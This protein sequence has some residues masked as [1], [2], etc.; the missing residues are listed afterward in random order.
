MRSILLAFAMF[1]RLPV[2]RPEWTGKNMRFIMAAFPAVGVVVGAA[3][4]LWLELAEALGFGPF[5]T[6]VGFAL[7]PLLLTGGIHMDGF[8]DTTDAL[9]SHGDREKK[10]RILKDPH[11][12]SFASFLAA[13]YLMAFA[14]LASEID[15]DS[16]ALWCFPLLFVLSRTAVGMAIV[17]CPPAKGSGL[18]KTFHDAAATR[19]SLAILGAVLFIVVF[20]FAWCGG[21]AGFAAALCALGAAGLCLYKALREFGG[22]GGDA[23]GWALLICEA[24]CL[25][26]LA[27]GFRLTAH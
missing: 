27:I 24:V 1:T 16:R 2:P 26:V 6:G 23:S 11:I 21:T 25:C 4:Y 14:A 3:T 17:L 15:A 9:A 5:L 19:I 10:L 12:G 7:T 18:G 8:C 13:A 20:L 22:Q